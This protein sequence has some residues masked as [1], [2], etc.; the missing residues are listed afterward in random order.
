MKRTFA[1]LTSFI[2]MINM[3]CNRFETEFDGRYDTLCKSMNVD[4]TAIK[5]LVS[6]TR[7]GKY[8]KVTSILISYNDSL[9]LESYFRGFSRN[10]LINLHSCTKS[11]VSILSGIAID[12]GKIQSVDSK[13]FDIFNEEKTPL[14]WNLQNRSI[15]IKNLLMMTAGWEWNEETIPY[16]NPTNSLILFNNAKNKLEHISDLRFSSNPGE[17]FYYNSASLFLA[18]MVLTK[19]TGMP[20]DS[21]ANKYLFSPL[22]IFKWKWYR[23]ADG[24]P[25]GQGDLFLRPVDFLKIG[26]LVCNGGKISKGYQIVSENWL[27]A[28]FNNCK[29][30][31]TKLFYYGYAW[32]IVSEKHP[33]LGSFA[34]THRIF[35]AAGMGGQILYVI[36]DLKLVIVSTAQND[37]LHDPDKNFISEA[38]LWDYILPGCG[39]KTL[40]AEKP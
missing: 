34:K 14:N 4:A 10:S 36:P 1:I 29:E 24:I 18:S 30:T 31:S 22:N 12:K 25:Y 38:I 16:D 11:I 32:Y 28:S 2:L 37:D 21:F 5:Q 20:A 15:T 33:E 40:K 39:Y 27:K 23:N 35:E 17:K 6:S 8:G 9:I 26:Q 7:Q 13:L 19:T 3:T